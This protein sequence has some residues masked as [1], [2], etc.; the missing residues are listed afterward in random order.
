MAFTAINAG[1]ILVLT[2]YQYV[3]NLAPPP[4][5]HT[6]SPFFSPSLISLTVSVDVKRRIFLLD[7]SAK[8]GSLY[9]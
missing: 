3:Y 5:Q 2:E 7:G 1:V 9:K 8:W 6:S 4:P